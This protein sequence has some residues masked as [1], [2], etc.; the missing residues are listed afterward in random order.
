MMI[1]FVKECYI[2]SK[3]TNHPITV[4]KYH[5][6][7]EGIQCSSCGEISFS[8]ATS[9]QIQKAKTE[10]LN[11]F[12]KLCNN[13]GYKIAEKMGTN[14]HDTPECLTCEKNPYKLAKKEV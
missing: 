11:K 7:F 14:W 10:Y 2:C 13:C 6:Q 4:T 5:K 8:L 12:S 9:K 1:D 3:G